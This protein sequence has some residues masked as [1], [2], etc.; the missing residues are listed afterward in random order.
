VR[1]GS[2]SSE[3]EKREGNYTAWEREKFNF[4]QERRECGEGKESSIL[5]K[6]EWVFLRF[7]A[8]EGCAPPAKDVKR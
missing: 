2:R 5:Q 8:T 4:S 6:R 7:A 3:K 1:V